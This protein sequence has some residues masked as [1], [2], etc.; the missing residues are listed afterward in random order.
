MTMTTLRTKLPL[1]LA[2][3]LLFVSGSSEA[4]EPLAQVI[5]VQGEVELQ[6]P[7]QEPRALAVGTQLDGRDV[8][9]TDFESFAILHLK[10]GHL[11]RIDE[12]LRLRVDKIAL[13][14]TTREAAPA[15]RQLA[16]LLYP[17]EEPLRAEALASAERT[18][19]WHSRITAVETVPAA[20]ASKGARSSKKSLSAARSVPMKPPA[21]PAPSASPAPPPP[22]REAAALEREEDSAR[23]M[24]GAA[25]GLAGAA[26]AALEAP[27]APPKTGSADL[28][29]S[30]AD[31]ALEGAR[32]QATEARGGAPAPAPALEKAKAKEEAKA[33]TSAPLNRRQLLRNQALRK[34]LFKELPPPRNV[35]TLLFKV[36][37]GKIVRARLEG[38]RPLPL[39][40]RPHLLGQA[41]KGKKD[42][43]G[44]ITLRLTRP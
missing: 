42:S 29:L 37:D 39:C 24:V 44:W 23:S 34:C 1:F 3:T 38:A 2:L 22:P 7:G 11:V 28:S 8:I 15:A 20:P 9:V 35:M 21:R 14:G 36:K 43:K 5:L 13:L 10:N 6:R 25:D 41:W 33:S 32:L 40:A 19:G 4:G 31:D 17:E 12:E 26:P 27:P 16:A 30:E 18:A